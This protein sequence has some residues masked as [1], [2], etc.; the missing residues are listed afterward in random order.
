MYDGSI[1]HGDI[2]SAFTRHV[3]GA[4]VRDYRDNGGFITICKNYRTIQWGDQTTTAKREVSVPAVT[5]CNLPRGYVTASSHF[6]GLKLHRPGWRVEF[7]R[8]SRH[9]TQVQKRAITRALHCGEV[10]YG[11]R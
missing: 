4:Y 9:L 2:I 6:A 3:P 10:F 8:A 5:L 7:R 1:Y 11:V